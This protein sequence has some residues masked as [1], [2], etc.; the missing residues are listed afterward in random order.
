MDQSGRT[1]RV[2]LRN[3]IEEAYGR[4]T[5][6]YTT[7]NKQADICL[8]RSSIIS[9]IQLILSVASTGAI[10]SLFA[11]ETRFQLWLSVILTAILALVSAYAK[12]QNLDAQ[13]LAHKKAADSMW[14]IRESYISLLTDFDVIDES[15]IVEQRDSLSEAV[16]EVYR[17]APKTS[18]AAYK[19]AQEALKESEEQYFSTEELDKMLPRVLRQGAEVGFVELEPHSTAQ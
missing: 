10:M 19:K 7:Q 16:A 14:P 3:Q 8:R 17:Q 6:S 11:T 1:Y 9:W 4:L 5:Y 18:P 13:A 15:R 12:S 2:A